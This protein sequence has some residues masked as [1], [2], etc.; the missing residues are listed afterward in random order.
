MLLESHTSL[1]FFGQ[2][3][4]AQTDRHSVNGM[5]EESD[6]M[7]SDL[8][9]SVRAEIPPNERVARRMCLFIGPVLVLICFLIDR[10]DMENFQ[11]MR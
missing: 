2:A 6:V 1:Y 8:E 5:K 4:R 9:Q 11:N 10:L 7:D 3:T